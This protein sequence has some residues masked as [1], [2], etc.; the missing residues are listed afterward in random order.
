M[1]QAA[2]ILSHSKNKNNIQNT[3]LVHQVNG[4]FYAYCMCMNNTGTLEFSFMSTMEARA[5]FMTAQGDEAHSNN[6]AIHVFQT[7]HMSYIIPTMSGHIIPS[8]GWNHCSW[9]S[10][11]GGN[12]MTDLNSVFS[13]F[14]QDCIKIHDLCLP[15]V[16]SVFRKITLA[17]NSCMS[18]RLY[19]LLMAKWIQPG[20]LH[21]EWHCW[22][23]KEQVSK[24]F[25]WS[26]VL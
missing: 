23:E 11:W 25:S 19:D 7:A 14:M 16:M 17:Q 8:W 4:W 12:F 20:T 15:C 10:L 6:L 3:H 21:F 1:L 26:I 18:D 24:C 5:K 22:S 13:F 9:Q 2:T